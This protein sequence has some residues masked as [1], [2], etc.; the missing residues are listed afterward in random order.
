MIRLMKL[1]AQAVHCCF[2]EVSTEPH[3][4]KSLGSDLL[5]IDFHLFMKQYEGKLA[6]AFVIDCLAGEVGYEQGSALHELT[7]SVA[8]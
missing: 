3:P 4:C 8:L 1:R 7:T 2:Y 6:T 5:P